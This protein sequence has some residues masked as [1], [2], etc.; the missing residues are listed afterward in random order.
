MSTDRNA[1]ADACFYILSALLPRLNEMKPGLVDE[2]IAGVAADRAGCA[3]DIPDREH[4]NATFN[5][6][7]RILQLAGPRAAS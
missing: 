6:A 4:V 3:Q 2:L 5:E 7:L 1:S